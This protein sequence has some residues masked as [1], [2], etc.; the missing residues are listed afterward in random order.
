[1]EG[2]V[3]VVGTDRSGRGGVRPELP[4]SV[5]MWLVGSV[6]MKLVDSLSIIDVERMVAKF[7]DSRLILCGGMERD[8]TIWTRIGAVATLRGH[9]ASVLYLACDDDNFQIAAPTSAS[10]H[11]SLTQKLWAEPA[12][13]TE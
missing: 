2:A 4:S 11:S 9:P 7:E 12:E 6:A 13:P 10:H 5:P 3:V 1:M 8:I